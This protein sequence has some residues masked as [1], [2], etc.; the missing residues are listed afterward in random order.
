VFNLYDRR[1]W[2]KI[3]LLNA[4][5]L[6][7]LGT[8]YLTN[9]L[10]HNISEQ[11]RIKVQLWANAYRYLNNA[12]DMSDISYQLEVIKNNKNIPIILTD[13]ED[14]I[15]D[16]RNLDSS[17]IKNN[18]DYLKSQLIV[19]EEKYDPIQIEIAPGEFSYIYYKDS[20]LLT[21][22]KY[23]PVVQLGFIAIFMIIAFTAY[24]S[25]RRAEQNRVWVGM[26]KET[27]H[28]LGTP[29]SSLVAWAEY[30]RP[31]VPPEESAEIIGEFE[32]DISRLQLIAERFSKIGS[33]PDLQFV[34]LHDQLTKNVDYMRRRASD[35][36]S[37]ELLGMRNVIAKVN[38]S[39]F[40]WVIENLLKNALDAMEG[41]G[42]IVLH[43]EDHGDTVNID[44]T[45]TGKGIANSNL[46]RV[47]EPGFST[48]KRGWGLGLSLSKRIIHDYHRGKIFVKDSV[49]GK[50]TTFR[51]VLRNQQ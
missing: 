11:E 33:Q 41:A 5:V 51:I 17:R 2:L 15:L 27:A 12:D 32:K 24:R 13:D 16:Y 30:F 26:A 23:Y 29:L 44:V 9:R 7:I 34:N 6:I 3:V 8:L 21:Q 25:T 10:V 19:M 48:K 1:Q 38:P 49:I 39:L 35:K 45:D 40:D 31:L 20:K 36:V 4:G 37:F 18:P 14:N 47:F 43:Y 46:S 28:Q 50:G 22:L 42:S